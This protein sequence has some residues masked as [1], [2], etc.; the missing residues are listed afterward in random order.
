MAFNHSKVF[1]I[2]KDFGNSLLMPKLSNDVSVFV[3]K[4]RFGPNNIC[5]HYN[6]VIKNARIEMVPNEKTTTEI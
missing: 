6:H 2:S 3:T 5:F 4:N 1:K